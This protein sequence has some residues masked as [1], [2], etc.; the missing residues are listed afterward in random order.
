[1]IRERLAKGVG[2]VWVTHDRA[3]AA[4]L[5]RRCLEFANGGVR[6]TTP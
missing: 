3:Q 5:A 2:V 4:R 1:M 6:E